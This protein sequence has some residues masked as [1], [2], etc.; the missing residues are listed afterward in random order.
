MFR[1][2][3]FGLLV[4]LLLSTFALVPSIA[5]QNNL[6][7]LLSMTISAGY[8]TFFRADSWSPI[9][10]EIENR[11]E[12]IRGNLLVRP[13]TSGLGIEHTYTTPVEIPNGRQSLFL[14]ITARDLANN[15]RVELVN[16]AGNTLIG[17]DSALRPL[18]ARDTLFVVVSG[19]TDS[20]LNLSNIHPTSYN[21]YSIRW[22][23]TNIPDRAEG[24]ASVNMLI[25]NDINTD[26]LT[27]AQ[28]EAISTWV[29][30]GGHLLVMGGGN[31]Q[32]T[33]SGITDLLPFSPT[34]SIT[35][36]DAT[37]LLHYGG[38]FDTT[39]TTDYTQTEGTI[40]TGAKIIAG[41]ADEPFIIR[42][43]IGNGTIDYVTVNL[44]A[45]PFSTWDAL[46]NIFLGLIGSSQTPVGWS[47]GFSDWV[48][49]RTAVQILPGVD[50]L[51]A[52]L[53]LVAFLGAYIV[54]IG[55]LNYLLLR[56][57]NRRGFAWITIPIFIIIFTILA[58]SVGIELRG[59][60]ARLNRLTVVQSWHNTDEAHIDQ[61][62]G[63]LAP[64]RGN[65]NL[66][67][68]DNRTLRP[69]LNPTDIFDLNVPQTNIEIRQTSQFAAIEVPV[70]ASFI[71]AFSTSGT[72]EKP[73]ISGTATWVYRNGSPLLRGSVRNNT[74]ITLTDAVILTR[75]TIQPIGNLEAGAVAT[76]ETDSPPIIRETAMPSAIEFARSDESQSYFS[77]DLISRTNSTRSL[78][79]ARDFLGENAFE[80]TQNATITMT[81]TTDNPDSERALQVANQR[82][83]L[84]AS[85]MVDQYGSRARGNRV[86]LLGWTETSPTQENMGTQTYSSVDTTLYIIE[87][88]TEIAPTAEEVLITR[89]QFIWTALPDSQ[90][91]N[92]SPSNLNTTLLDNNIV[93]FRFTPIAD[94]QLAEVTSLTLV[95]ERTSTSLTNTIEMW[96]WQNKEWVSFLIGG[97]NRYPIEDY[98]RFIG[99]QNAVQVRTVTGLSGGS[100]YI[101]QLGIEQRGIMP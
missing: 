74:E 37:P 4:V 13:A 63:L 89:D 82:R 5:A 85:F 87:I 43:T 25:F 67:M 54:L 16:E 31:W 20:Q 51:P 90:I 79:N 49:A 26:Q 46:S 69:L 50:L 84:I 101:Q 83:A 10:I 99:A 93:A 42:Q 27:L 65:Y 7:D 33:A 8:D 71:S 44:E 91:G 70:D 96:D 94:A 34:N 12:T 2:F 95:L 55:P 35:I 32:A 9:R 72:I 11:G 59:T 80:Y 39:L 75:G 88:S 38:D 24:L 22:R 6:N 73:D 23:I 58:W 3:R 68:D 100:R 61:L 48:N 36:S 92:I 60:D 21:S 41:T 1:R 47:Y 76:F 18:L 64:R 19:A 15:V 52:V 45:P 29:I 28:R 77:T 97:Q 86:F 53:S 78:L 30:G 17:T 98:A 56:T 62:I 40:H 14:Y 57:I 66:I 81:F